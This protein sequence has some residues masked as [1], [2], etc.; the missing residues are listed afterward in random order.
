MRKQLLNQEQSGL[1]GPFF[2]PN[3]STTHYFSSFLH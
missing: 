3:G 2:Y 1:L